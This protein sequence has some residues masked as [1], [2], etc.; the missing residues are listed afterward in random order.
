MTEPVET[1]PATTR[2]DEAAGLMRGLRIH[3]LVVKEGSKVVGLLSAGDLP[4][5]GR[6]GRVVRDV[7]SPNVATIEDN[8]TV[9]RAANVMRGRSIGS[10][11]VMR[12]GRLAGIVT[13]SD[14]LDLWERA[15]DAAWN[16]P[17]PACTTA[18]RT[19]S[20][21]AG[22]P[23]DTPAG[24]LTWLESNSSFDRK[25]AKSCCTAVWLSPTPCASRWDRNPSV[26]SSRRNGGA[27]SSAMTV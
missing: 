19:A 7:M 17:V 23:G 5:A 26:C 22:D 15:P 4:R 1:I 14:L 9:R 3:H 25:R 24:G 11:V 8:E 18:C 10:L 6:D 21:I 27:R 2:I 13:V 20:S 12:G 16:P